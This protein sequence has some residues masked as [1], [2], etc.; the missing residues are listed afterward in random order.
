MT[1][2]FLIILSLSAAILAPFSALA[3]LLLL[4]VALWRERWPMRG[5]LPWLLFG[6]LA[7]LPASLLW[8]QSPGLSLPQA[9]VLLCLPLGWLA[10]LA[11]HRR[12]QLSRLLEYGLPALLAMLLLW[13][14]LQGPNTFTAKPQ[15]PFNDP[16]TYAA[17]LNLLVLPILAHYLAADLAR[18]AA[19]WRTGQLALLAGAAFV[20]L[21]TASRGASLALLLVLPPLFWLARAQPD[22]KRKLALLATVAACA[23]LA[24][25]LVGGGANVGQRL[26]NTV[27]GGDPSRLMLLKS[28]WLMIQD[29]LWL[30]TGL[31]TFRLLYPQYRYADEAGTAGGWVHNDYLQL[32]LE[33]GFPMLLLLLGLAA[34]V[35]WR[36]WRTLRENTNT[37]A[38]GAALAAM[39]AAARKGETAWSWRAFA[40]CASRRIAAKAAPT[41]GRLFHARPDI[42]ERMGYLAAIAAILLHALVNFLFFFAL[43][44]LLVGL[45][46]ARL[47][48][49]FSKGG[50]GGDSFG[51]DDA[52]AKNKS[53]MKLL[54]YGTPAPL[55]ERGEVARSSE[56]ARAIRLAVGGYALILG[57]LLLGQVAVEGLLG[58]ARPLQK[59][60]LTWDV[61]Y[62]RYQ[63][64][65]WVSVL[66]PFHPTP[67]QIM[68]LELASLSGGDGPMRDEALSRMESGM[69]RAPCYLPYANDALAL[70]QQ[71]P[72]DAAL[73]ERGQAIVARNL[74]CNARH[75]LSY[76]HAGGFAQTDAQALE[77][78]RAGMAASPHV[79]DDLLLTA[80]ILSRT[81]SGQEQALAALAEQ[82]AQ[83]IRHLEENPGLRADQAFWTEAQHKL[84]RLAGKRYLELVPPRK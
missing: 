42:L 10:G 4:P 40:L 84:Y 17:V 53:L 49:P 41:A 70:I 19:W 55:W 25:Y 75:G 6:W 80:A 35:A 58:Q 69:Q 77:W 37:P 24:A 21:L 78:W 30:G 14:L 27:S 64:A 20:A 13:G 52:A 2:W 62:P 43:V 61:A 32:W 63:V 66:A 18:Q 9:A 12:G 31:G 54:P 76:Y 51:T 39:R 47:A 50:R 34:W 59:I 8:S 79:A 74:D 57:F 56:H 11:L 44:S 72:L 83:T 7:W 23:Y 38:V 5:A 71:G 15:G 45:Y 33:A 68:G 81:I 16:N 3:A 26:V 82:M 22:F 29:H 36:M 1:I 60:L 73:R 48:P 28:A 46:L 67:Q 65:Y